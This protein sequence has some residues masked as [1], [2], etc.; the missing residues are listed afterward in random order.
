MSIWGEQLHYSL[1]LLNI[2]YI[3]Y[4]KQYG[5]YFTLA[6]VVELA[7]KM[8]HPGPSVRASGGRW[9]SRKRILVR[10]AEMGEIPFLG[11]FF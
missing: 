7:T 8:S 4:P 2:L 10:E 1:V 5:T 3:K 9:L 11:L 6:V